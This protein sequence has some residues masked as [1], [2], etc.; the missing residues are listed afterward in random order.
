MGKIIKELFNRKIASNFKTKLLL[1]S[2]LCVFVS[3]VLFSAMVTKGFDRLYRETT[4]QVNGSIKTLS[5]DYLNGYVK[6]TGKLIED[7]INS[8]VMELST[9]T[10]IYQKYYDRKADYENIT[11]ALE[12]NSLIEDKLIFNGKWMQNEKDADTAVMVEKYLLNKDGTIPQKIKDELRPTVI[13][14]L[15]LPSFYENGNRKLLVYFGGSEGQDFYRVAPWTD[16]AGGLYKVYPQF[17]ETPMMETF[18]PGYQAAWESR[19]KTE[20]ALLKNKKSTV[21]FK[22][23]TQ[24]GVTGD[25]IITVGN[26]VWDKNRDKLEGLMSMD[27]EI[28]EL[29]KYVSNL[30]IEKGIA[31]LTQSNGNVFA[32]SSEGEKLLGMKSVEDSTSQGSVGFNMMT[33]FF[34]DSEYADVQGIKPPEGNTISTNTIKLEGKDYLL[35]QKNLS[36][37]TSWQNDKKFYEESWTLGILMP[38]SSITATSDLMGNKINVLKSNIVALLLVLGFFLAVLS[39]I[40][41]FYVTK[42]MTT[43]LITLE[44]AALGAVNEN[45]DGRVEITS[46]DEIGRLGIAFNK[47]M[48]D[49][50]SAIEQLSAQNDLLKKEIGDRLSR[51]KQIKYMEE[52]DELTSLPRNNV[53]YSKLEDV[54]KEK[55][56][57]LLIIGLDNFRN[58]NEVLGHEGG[59][60]ILRLAA[61]RIVNT[62][63]DAELIARFSGDEFAV[64]FSDIH[65]TTVVA[66]KAELIQQ[67]IK[68]VY[69]V[70]GSEIYL[71]AS[72]G[73]SM[74]P[75][76]SK[77]TSD[78]VKYAASALINAKLKGKGRIQFYDIA[79][80]KIAEK[81]SKLLG[82]LSYALKRDEFVVVYQPKFEISTEKIVG[83]EAL[84]RWRNKLNGDVSPNLFIPM[85]ED[86]GLITEIGRWVLYKACTQAVEWMRLS[87]KQFTMAVNISPMQFDQ[88]DFRNEIETVI[89]ETGIRPECL[90]LEVTESLFINDMEK[91]GEILNGLRA[92][93]VK[94]AMDDF[95]KGYSSLGYLK[96]LPIDSLK[97]DRSFIM[98]IPD[99]DDGKIAELIISLGKGLGVRTVA[100]GVETVQQLEFLRAA[101]CEE[102]QGFLLGRPVSAEETVLHLSEIK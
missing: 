8:Y 16:I 31:F 91:A 41:I 50:K 84:L 102:I 96:K 46:T 54:V 74:F 17:V 7:K 42:K 89:K 56:G 48:K 78:L 76:D 32:L 27:I 66:E 59:N 83:F 36:P 51:E 47:M 61:R 2:F 79:I 77:I 85:A 64:L 72:V 62:V 81:R 10:D 44:K 82:E 37:L 69:K 39:G 70:F 94:V 23:I 20:P 45:Y 13:L 49:I 43:G 18:N 68:Q 19:I 38:M 73:I 25:I 99:K 35:M 30:K 98:D 33:R 63:K 26:P 88:A 80:N 3:L 11:K 90:E 93:G 6:V 75:S 86:S 97:V 87:G 53:L 22:Q 15:I 65:S 71:T 24:D 9:L 52:Y 100:E 55:K 60:S 101:G 58:A 14:D 21:T 29:V 57:A 34:K 4:I 67:Q 95:G 5:L 12:T 28:S 40:V 92:T 1:V